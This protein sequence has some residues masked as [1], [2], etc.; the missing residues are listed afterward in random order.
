MEQI[1]VSCVYCRETKSIKG[2]HTHVDRAHLKLTKYSNGNNKSYHL[3]AEKA[4]V[5]TL[6]DKEEY[7]KY[8]KLCLHCNLKL[9]FK[10]RN[11][12]FCNASC[13]ATYT[14]A[15]K[16]FSKI[17][18]GPIK[19]EIITFE[20]ECIECKIHFHTQKNTQKFCSRKCSIHNR[21]KLIRSQRPA[22]IN[23]RADCAFKFNLKNFPDEFDFSLIEKYGWYSAANR[24]NNLAGISRDHIISV[25]YGFDNNIDPAIISHPANCRLITHTENSSKNQ[26]S[27]LTLNELLFKIDKWNKKYNSP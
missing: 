25:K 15:R 22:L 21:N 18:T 20:K 26:K 2:L 13:S 23:Y 10:K 14:N 7:L 19:K 12:K 8:P 4:K 5:K 6:R 24:G 3:F 9:D 27:L 17:K 1:L 16:D 11:G